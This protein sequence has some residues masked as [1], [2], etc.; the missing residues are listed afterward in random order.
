LESQYATAERAAALSKKIAAPVQLSQQ[1]LEL[2]VGIP[3]P[4]TSSSNFHR[5]L[6]AIQA[7]GFTTADF[8]K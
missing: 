6:D 7:R 1:Q 4:R 5:P 8:A 2:D 3:T